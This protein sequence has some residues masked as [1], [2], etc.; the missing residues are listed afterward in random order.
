ME[1]ELKKKIV[2]ISYYLNLRDTDRCYTVYTYFK[3]KGYDVKMLCGNYDHNSKQTV[4]YGMEDVEE[5]S[6][7]PY[8]KNMSSI[9]MISAYK[10]G[11]DVRKKLNKMQ[12]DI[13]YVVGPPNS[14]AYLVRKNAKRI[15]ARLVSDIY[16]LYPETI[17]VSE[18]A[19]KAA[20]ICGFWWWSYLRDS[21]I[22]KAD[23]FI[24][25]CQYYFSLLNIKESDRLK[26]VP[27]CKSSK[28]IKR[29]EALPNDTLNILYLG[30]L[31]GNYDFEGLIEIMQQLKKKEKPAKLH[32]IGDG[33]R[34][35]WLLSELD[36]KGINYEFFGRIYDDEVKA[37]VMKKCHFGFNGFKENVAIALS[38]K[39]MEYMS[40][41]LALINC[42][43]EDTWELV[44]NKNIGIN[45]TGEIID[46]AV[47]KLVNM[48]AQEICEMQ[49]NASTQYDKNYSYE[50]YKN[51]MDEIFG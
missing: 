24:G 37:Q 17:P 13:V 27:L 30:A 31:T 6:V 43:K 3:D 25:S 4:S 33:P 35:E 14:T 11:L 40:N 48:T 8:K 2:I 19:K 32:I 1:A 21:V 26:I 38:Y 45:Y 18:K 39:S 20:K 49:N 34:K 42:C 41:A 16:D 44:K 29:T 51:K 12:A 22:K 28:S 9:R 47:E 46:E 50:C 5:I 36:N 23:V 15:G 7:M 10:F